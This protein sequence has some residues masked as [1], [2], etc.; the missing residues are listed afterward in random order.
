M[1]AVLAVT[2]TMIAVVAVLTFAV[3]VPIPATSGYVHLGD[4]GVFFSALAFGPWI[5]G[6]A[7]GVGCALADLLSGY[8]VWAPLTLV[9][10][11]LQGLVTGLLGRGQGLAGLIVAWVA[12]AAVLVAVYFFGEWYVYG[13]GY[14]GALAE[15]VPNLIQV[16]VGGA[17]GIPLLLAVR[18]AYPPIARLV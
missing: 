14:A 11:G 9:A 13:L 8:A 10:H 12:G 6:L 16:A 4:A 17:V 3:Q 7:G 2:A 1:A 15:I 5:G 18:K